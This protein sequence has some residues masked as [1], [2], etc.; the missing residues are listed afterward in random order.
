MIHVAVV[1][2][3]HSH[4]NSQFQFVPSNEFGQSELQDDTN[5]SACMKHRDDTING[6]DLLCKNFNTSNK[7][8]LHSAKQNN[9][10]NTSNKHRLKKTK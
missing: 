10:F 8:R 7:D 9:Y 6:Y 2:N 1:I 4:T 5:E 3:Y